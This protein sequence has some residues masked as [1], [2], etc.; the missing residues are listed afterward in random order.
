MKDAAS[1]MTPPMPVKVSTPRRM[2]MMP[3]P[4]SIARPRRGGMTMPKRMIA[5][6]TT[7][8][9]SVCP[10][11]HSAPIIAEPRK[12]CWRLTMVA[13]ATIWSASVACRTPSRNPRKSKD[14]RLPTVSVNSFPKAN[15]RAIIAFPSHFAIRVEPVS[16][17]EASMPLQPMIRGKARCS[18]ESALHPLGFIG[19]GQSR[20][21]AS[22]ATAL[23]M[24]GTTTGTP[25]S[26]IPRSTCCRW[27]S[28]S[29]PHKRRNGHPYDSVFV[30]V[31]R[32]RDPAAERDLLDEGGAEPDR[33]AVSICATMFWVQGETGRHRYPG[34][35]S[36]NRE[37]AITGYW[38]AFNETAEN[39]AALDALQRHLVLNDL[40]F[41]LVF[42]LDRQDINHD[43]LYARCREVE[44]A[45]DG[46]LYLW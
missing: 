46:Y 23:A 41:L 4:N 17:Q 1:W 29:C 28:L 21:P 31:R 25:A 22:T 15:L 26:P 30:E 5:P 44:A 8:I 34:G 36:V 12:L 43:W 7:R 16:S 13:M 40:F 2:S 27:K 24:A 42:I 14:A 33:Q 19:K 11:P 20:L 9:V 38:T 10:I 45:P 6:P 35:G 18:C 37:Q 39:P 3:T 32:L